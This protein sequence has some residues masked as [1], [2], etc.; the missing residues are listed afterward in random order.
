MLSDFQHE[1]LI[2]F[3]EDSSLFN[4]SDALKDSNV[5]M[6]TIYIRSVILF[7]CYSTFSMEI[8]GLPIPQLS[9]PCL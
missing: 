5:L 9:I 3:K 1:K 6:R 8:K 4:N 2:D 7:Y